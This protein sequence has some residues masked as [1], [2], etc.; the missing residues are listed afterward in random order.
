M[1]D[2]ALWPVD[3]HLLI[4]TAES[5]LILNRDT[6][7]DFNRKVGHS[8]VAVVDPAESSSCSVCSLTSS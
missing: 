5:V 1:T 7:C 4:S 3:E 2:V 8:T 6:F